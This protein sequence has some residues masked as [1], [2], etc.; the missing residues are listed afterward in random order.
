MVCHC[1]RN[2]YCH[3][4][5]CVVSNLRYLMQ[6]SELSRGNQG[7]IWSGVFLVCRVWGFFCG[8]LFSFFPPVS[9]TMKA[10]P[11]PK[12]MCLGTPSRQ[13]CWNGGHSPQICSQRPP[14]L[15]DRPISWLAFAASPVLLQ[16][17]HCLGGAR[18]V[19]CSLPVDAANVCTRNMP[20]QRC[21][22][23]PG[24]GQRVPVGPRA[25]IPQDL[26]APQPSASGPERM[27]REGHKKQ[28]RGRRQGQIN[29]L[30]R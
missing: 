11:P 8:F 7:V 22:Q 28:E 2:N 16:C 6:R 9:S 18:W 3:V 13:R 20:R 12:N 27:G 25:L 5:I 14:V 19:G 23:A 15:A 1:D 21:Q 17:F 30:F 4:F 29:S 24:L 26:A 10:F